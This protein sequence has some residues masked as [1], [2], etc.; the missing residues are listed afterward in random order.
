MAALNYRA[1]MNTNDPRL[2]TALRNA[3]KG[4]AA[5]QG[6]SSSVRGLYSSFGEQEGSRLGQAELAGQ[7]MANL[8]K[9]YDKSNKLARKKFAFDKAATLQQLKMDKDRMKDATLGSYL[10]LGLNALGTAG[11]LYASYQDRK[12]REQQTAQTEAATDLWV[13]RNPQQ[14]TMMEMTYPGAFGLRKYLKWPGDYSAGT[15][16]K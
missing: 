4:N 14:A 2:Q 13:R 12:D 11:N 15:S 9:Y 7:K 16:Y 10:G 3:S 1:R 6:G 8:Q 5:V